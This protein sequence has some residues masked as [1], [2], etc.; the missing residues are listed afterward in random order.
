MPGK[1]GL[2]HTIAALVALALAPLLKHLISV[3]VNA[4]DFT[5]AIEA[6]GAILAEYPKN[7]LAVDSTTTI[8]HLLAVAV[9]AFVWGY[10][11]HVSRHE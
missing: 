1:S 11:Y 6:I 3:L 10:A 4:Q 2:S 5:A 9:L 8:L 7:P